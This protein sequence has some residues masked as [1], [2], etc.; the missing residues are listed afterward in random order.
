ML[1]QEGLLK[2]KVASSLQTKSLSN[3]KYSIVSGGD[4]KEL[5]YIFKIRRSLY[6]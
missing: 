3:L 5:R 6:F 1:L 4:Q 2:C